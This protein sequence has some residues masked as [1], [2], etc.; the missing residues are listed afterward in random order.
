M[1]YAQNTIY[2]IMYS[3]DLLLFQNTGLSCEQSETEAKRGMYR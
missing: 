3:N 2:Y 1:M